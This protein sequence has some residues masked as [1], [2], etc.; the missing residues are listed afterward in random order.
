[1]IVFISLHTINYFI[2]ES[3]FYNQNI[4]PAGADEKVITTCSC[5]NEFSTA[6]VMMQ[7]LRQAAQGLLS[8]VYSFA[9][10]VK[11]TI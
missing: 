5:L 1:V 6:S 7:S 8:F 11:A 2:F 4:C 9:F 3:T 10:F